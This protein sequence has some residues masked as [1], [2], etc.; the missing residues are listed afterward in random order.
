VFDHIVVVDWSAASTPRLGRDSIWVCA[1][2]VRSGASE[3]V[4]LPIRAAAEAWLLDHLVRS[5]GRVLVGFDFPFGYPAGF[6]TAAG[7]TG[8][9]PWLAAWRHLAGSVHDDESNRSNRFEVAAGLNARVSG[10]PGPFWGCRPG[11]E[12]TF[13]TSRRVFRFPH[14]GLAEFRPCEQAILATGRRVSSVWQLWGAGSVGSQALTGIPVVA[15]LRW[16]AALRGRAR[17]WP[18]ETGFDPD[19]AVG[20]AD[21]VVLT[22]CWPG[23]VPLDR[24]LHVVRD[25][26]QV[27]GLARHLAGLDARG[28]IGAWFAPAL[29]GQVAPAALT[30][31]AWILGAEVPG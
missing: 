18:F 29:A 15:R 11:A 4:N 27:L 31:E 24:S 30:E 22:E 2:D 5:T 28:A 21:A 1:L 10:G 19:P 7:V 25:A 3:L 6:A 9:T 13:L 8:T 23:I 26:A 16:S 17:V 20:V 12:S 14:R